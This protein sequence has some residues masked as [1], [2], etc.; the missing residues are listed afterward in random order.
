MKRSSSLPHIP[1]REPPPKRV[2]P[3]PQLA[4]SRKRSSL[5]SLTDDVLSQI[6]KRIL[7]SVSIDVAASTQLPTAVALAST[8][9]RLRHIFF[10]S[11]HTMDGTIEHASHELPHHYHSAQ[12]TTCASALAVPYQLLLVTRANLSLRVLR[13]APLAPAATTLILSSAVDA[14]LQLRELHFTDRG[15]ITASLACSLMSLVTLTHLE[16]REPA[17]NLLA[18]IPGSAPLESLTLEAIPSGCAEQLLKVL[19]QTGHRLDSLSLAF[20]NERR[21]LPEPF[22]FPR[23][24]LHRIYPNLHLDIAKD[25]SDVLTF[26]VQNRA[27]RLPLLRYLSLTTVGVDLNQES[28]DLINCPSPV[29]G[30]DAVTGTVHLM[31]E[32]ASA[33]P[34]KDVLH[35]LRYVEL[36]TDHPLLN[37]SVNALRGLLS[38]RVHMTLH[39]NHLT[40]GIPPLIPDTFQAEIDKSQKRITNK[41]VIE[42]HNSS[43]YHRI[44][45][46]RLES[47]LLCNTPLS[48]HSDLSRLK[49]LDISSSSFCLKYGRNVD[50]Y[51]PRLVSLLKAAEPSLKTIRLT[52]FVKGPPASSIGK[53]YIVDVLCHA[54]H[55]TVLELSDQFLIAAFY[56]DDLTDLFLHMRNF[57]TIRFGG[58]KWAYNSIGDVPRAMTEF[59]QILPNFL[60]SVTKSC[61]LLRHL[62]LLSL[63]PTD[64]I[65]QFRSSQSLRDS[66]R[67]LDALERIIPGVDVSTVRTQLRSWCAKGRAGR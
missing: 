61:P 4:P 51:R 49:T 52:T 18:A 14:C 57:R 16:V 47:L 31:R 1:Y 56:R 55:A 45:A 26:I 33:E 20:Y 41:C 59:F 15:A 21:F 6:F 62:V 10:T 30:L 11:V 63:Y 2:R 34:S 9:R 39:V 46:A 17:S 48:K 40:V 29:S 60:R 53:A 42:N 35:P 19:R 8:C 58:L 43:L 3:L 12:C 44:T 37:A 13:L 65:A 27:T 7:Q 64:F 36:R 38:P 5:L 23:F 22:A 67:A 24:N 54:P 25:V 50:A 66:L 32:A 28:C